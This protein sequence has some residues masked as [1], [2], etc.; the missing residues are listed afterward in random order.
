MLDSGVQS[1]VE[2]FFLLFKVLSFPCNH[3]FRLLV[4]DSL[5]E[6]L[7]GTVHF[8]AKFD[9]ILACLLNASCNQGIGTCN[10]LLDVH[11]PDGIP[12]SSFSRVGWASSCA[13]LDMVSHKAYER[14]YR[15]TYWLTTLF[16]KLFFCLFLGFV[17]RSLIRFKLLFESMRVLRVFGTPFA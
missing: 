9:E 7:L 16:L 10:R 11:H 12:G 1:S 2:Y 13:D 17:L 4:L 5:V 6:F 15:I 14:L 8:A 3:T